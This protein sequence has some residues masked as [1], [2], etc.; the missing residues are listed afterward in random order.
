ML[1]GKSE[2]PQTVR[3][4]R[5]RL[6][7]TQEALGAVLHVSRVT[8]A[9]WEGGVQ[10]PTG[11]VAHALDF[12]WRGLELTADAN[13]MEEHEFYDKADR[14]LEHRIAAMV[15]SGLFAEEGARR[16]A[17]TLQMSET[18]EFDKSRGLAQMFDLSPEDERLIGFGRQV[19]DFIE[20]R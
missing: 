1:I 20:G 8:V 18:N 16:I 15:K 6:G 14:R 12:L 17:V 13:L 4:I 5:E 7:Y 9:R 19:L 3:M 2:W 10:T 11:A